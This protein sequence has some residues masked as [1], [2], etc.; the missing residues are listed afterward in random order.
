MVR[1]L[2]NTRLSDQRVNGEA[3]LETE[4]E[5][6]ERYVDADGKYSPPLA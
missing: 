5:V 1:V 6:D 3:V 4:E 2:A